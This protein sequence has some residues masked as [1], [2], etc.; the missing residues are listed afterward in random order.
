MRQILYIDEDDRKSRVAEGAFSAQRASLLLS[1]IPLCAPEES[2]GEFTASFCD[3]CL[4]LKYY[5][6]LTF[7][8]TVNRLN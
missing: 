3:S 8:N 6:A 5:Q 4:M 1:Q 7:G 2:H